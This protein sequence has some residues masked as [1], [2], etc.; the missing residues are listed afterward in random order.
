MQL[1]VVFKKGSKV[2]TT[3]SA[4]DVYVHALLGWFYMFPNL[5]ATFRRD[6]AA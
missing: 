4:K 3:T 6:I 2:N 5:T 1:S